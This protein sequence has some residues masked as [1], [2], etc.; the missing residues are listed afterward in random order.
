LGN[1]PRYNQELVGEQVIDLAKEKWVKRKI[2]LEGGEKNT[3]YMY[4]KLEKI[5]EA[6]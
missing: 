6:V 5:K 3:A 4:V 2:L 1:Q